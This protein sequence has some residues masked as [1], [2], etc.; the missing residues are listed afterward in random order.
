MKHRDLIK[1]I[2]DAALFRYHG[3]ERSMKIR[4][5]KSY[6]SQESNNY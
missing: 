4:Q 6:E 5:N 2:K 1:K 3:T